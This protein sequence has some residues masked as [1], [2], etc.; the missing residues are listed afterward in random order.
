MPDFDLWLEF[1]VWRAAG[2]T[3]DPLDDFFNMTITLPC[4]DQYALNVWTFAFFD[5]A[6]T[7]LLKFAALTRAVVRFR[8]PTERIEFVTAA[9][10]LEFVH[11]WHEYLLAPLQAF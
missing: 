7:D 2:D 11:R 8:Y 5:R 6:I 4:G 3:D 1:E 9:T 10:T